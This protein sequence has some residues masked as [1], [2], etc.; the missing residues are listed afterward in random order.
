MPEDNPARAQLAEME[1]WADM[2]MEHYERNRYTLSDWF[3]M[4]PLADDHVTGVPEVH[5]DLAASTETS[6][7]S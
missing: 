7:A 5:S 2:L 1:A 4:P 6:S 3:G